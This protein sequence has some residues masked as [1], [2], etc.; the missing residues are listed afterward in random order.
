MR[1]SPRGEPGREPPGD[2]VSEKQ[3][4][5]QLMAGVARVLADRQNTRENL[6]RRL[7]RDEPQAFAQLDRPPGN[8]IQQRSGARIMDRPTACIHRSPTGQARGLKT[9]GAG[10]PRQTFAQLSHLRPLAT[11]KDDPKR[12]QQHQFGMP[13][14]RCRNIRP[15]CL[16]DK[17]RQSFDV[18][19]HLNRPCF[20][21]SRFERERPT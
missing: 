19:A 7:T 6:H 16:G 9:H 18:F 3:S 5:Q 13:L 12:I 10:R 20:A 4:R 15:L 11:R 2:I 21:G 8:P 14:H 17:L 1:K